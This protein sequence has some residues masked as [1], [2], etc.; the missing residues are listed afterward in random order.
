[1]CLLWSTNWGFISQKTTFFIVSAVRTWNLNNEWL[2]WRRPAAVY[3]TRRVTVSS[4]LPPT[5]RSATLWPRSQSTC[6]WEQRSW[7]VL[8]AHSVWRRSLTIANQITTIYQH[9]LNVEPTKRAGSSHCCV[10]P[11][12]RDNGAIS[13]TAEQLVRPPHSAEL[14]AR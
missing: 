14:R 7:A 2:W 5:A 4:V 9:E 8:H 3:P 11:Q 12:C 1:M 10:T 6:R 13:V